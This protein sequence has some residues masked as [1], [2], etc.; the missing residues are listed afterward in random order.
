ML[1][2]ALRY[3]FSKK[4]FLETSPKYKGNTDVM[5]DAITENFEEKRKIRKMKKSLYERVIGGELHE[6]IIH[7][8]DRQL[9]F[10]HMVI[11]CIFRWGHASFFFETTRKS[12]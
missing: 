11:F 2:Q 7:N 10:I 1:R 5:T 6:E 8:R 4:T 3:I 9:Y 12:I